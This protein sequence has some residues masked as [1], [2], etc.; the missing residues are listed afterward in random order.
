VKFRD[1]QRPRFGVIRAASF[2]EDAYS[3]DIDSRGAA[4]LHKCF[5]RLLAD[6]CSMGLK[7][8]PMRAAKTGPIGG[9][10]SHE[11]IVLGGDPGSPR[12]CAQRRRIFRCPLMTSI[13]NGDLPRYP[14]VTSVYTATEMYTTPRASSARCR[15]DKR[16]STREPSKSVR[17]FTRHQ[18][19]RPM[20]ATVAGADGAEVASHGRLLGVRRLAPR[21][22]S[23]RPCHD[24][25]ESKCRSGRAVQGY[26]PEPEAGAD[27]PCR[28]RQALS[29]TEEARGAMSLYTTPTN[30]RGAKFAAPT[31]L[32]LPC[33]A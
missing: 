23:S 24:D 26:H 33:R 25:P 20:K 8:I 7:A 27:T 18:I 16:F 12:L 3:F 22:A 10:L 14:Q 5:V 19:F 21:R 29:R 9:D 2:L 31:L 11:F 6:L 15:G 17:S 13:M 32:A 4:F 30:A 1:E 28:L